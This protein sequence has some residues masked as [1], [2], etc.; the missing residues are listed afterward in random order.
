MKA[1]SDARVVLHVLFVL[2]C[3]ADFFMNKS[4]I[5]K[6]GKKKNTTKNC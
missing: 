6:L 1:F 4:F 3:F 5:P 2:I